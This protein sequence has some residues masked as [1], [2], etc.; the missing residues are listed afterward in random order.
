MTT[1]LYEYYKVYCIYYLKAIMFY[2]HRRMG[3]FWV[4]PRSANF[5]ENTF[6]IIINIH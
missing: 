4:V 5:S 2:A 3:I 6:K 1:M